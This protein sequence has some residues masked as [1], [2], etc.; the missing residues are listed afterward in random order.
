MCNFF[1]KER[2]NHHFP[3]LN[4]KKGVAKILSCLFAGS[5]MTYWAFACMM[6]FGVAYFMQTNITAT[7]GYMIQDMEN[8][9]VKLQEENNKLN[10][11]YIQRQSMANIVGSVSKMDMVPVTRVDVVSANGSV[12]ALK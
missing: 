7:K 5:K 8:Q 10:L 9:V 12:V 6:V 4:K 1:K 2:S 11:A 3:E